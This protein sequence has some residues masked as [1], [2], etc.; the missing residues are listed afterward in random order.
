MKE[1]H[2]K[3]MEGVRGFRGR[4]SSMNKDVPRMGRRLLLFGL[5]PFKSEDVVDG[6]LA[7]VSG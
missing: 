2:L 4:R 7:E 3:K 6:R 1:I 5:E